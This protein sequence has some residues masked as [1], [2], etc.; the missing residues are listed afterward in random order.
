MENQITLKDIAHN[1]VFTSVGT[2]NTE[3]DLNIFYAYIRHNKEFLSYF[4]D[5]IFSLNGNQTII[6]QMS[7]KISDILSNNIHILVTANLGHTFGTMLLDLTIMTYSKQLPYTYVWKFSNDVIVTPDIFLKK[8]T[9]NKDFYYI[10]NIGYNIFNTYSKDAL[11]Q[12]LMDQ[13]FYYPQTNY[14]IIKNNIEFYPSQDQIYS[15]KQEYEKIKLTNPNIQPWHAIDGCD[16]E[17][18][19]AK[20]VELNNLTKQHLLSRESTSSIVH[21]IFDQNMHDG[22]HKNIAYVELGG[23]CH[24]HYFGQPIAVVDHIL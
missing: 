12:A 24:Y 5:I 6:E 8:V 16:C 22:S 17:H 21:F 19:L 11:V 18:M 14:Y 15:L 23:L 4:K 13:S 1:S 20:T 3:N 7:T 10:N 9:P 2:L